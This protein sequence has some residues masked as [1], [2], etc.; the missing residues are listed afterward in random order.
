MRFR[1]A[2]AKHLG[3]TITPEIAAEIEAE[4]FHQPD[5]S[6][7]PRQFEPL[8]HQGYVIGVESF[9]EILA[10]LKPLHAAHWGETE[11]HRHRVKLNPDYQAMAARERAGR[12]IQF[13][14]R[15]DGELV[16]HLQMYLIESDHTQTPVS[17][18]NTLFIRQDHR[19]GMLVMKLLR[20]A[21]RALV[22]VRGPHMI[23]A[24]TKLANR[25]DVLMRRMGYEPFAM[26]FFKFVEP[27]TKEGAAGAT[28]LA[29]T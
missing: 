19:G 21:E 29:A 3:K 18:E 14:V 5:R 8:V 24:N 12:A 13:T 9:R 2:M 28:C 6:I 17:E 20:Y 10:E 1:M 15:H 22:R 25:A 26:Q 7:D 23:R 4:A 11:L 27:T 16:G